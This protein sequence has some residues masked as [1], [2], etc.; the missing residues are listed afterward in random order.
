MDAPRRFRLP[1]IP[2]LALFVVAAVAVNLPA[3]WFPGGGGAEEDARRAEV[4][5]GFATLTADPGAGAFDFLETVAALSGQEA[6]VRRDR[7]AHV[8]PGMLAAYAARIDMP[9][10]WMRDA[11][12]D[13]DY[14]H[15]FDIS[16]FDVTA[17]AFAGHG[18]AGGWRW[19]LA[20]SGTKDLSPEGAPM[21]WCAR[22]LVVWDA[23]AWFFAPVGTDALN[24][25]LGQAAPE[26][27]EAARRDG[28]ACDGARGAS[29]QAGAL[30]APAQQGQGRD[31]DD[32]APGPHQDAHQPVQQDKAQ[33]DAGHQER[34]VGGMT[35][36]AEDEEGGQRQDRGG[37]RHDPSEVGTLF[38]FGA[39]GHGPPGSGRLP[40][41]ALS[42]R[43]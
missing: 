35:G 9:A 13:P 39:A 25:M 23:E 33:H 42:D 34:R 32:I 8:L 38:F 26:L 7:R 31:G 24:A 2:V 37:H 6:R 14:A 5:S 20:A 12:L 21:G 22:W 40:L 36:G 17:P 29:E 28:G 15:P 1:L 27:A 18:I 19:G 11:V 41:F 10:D 43:V 3:S 4:F 30:Q 16:D